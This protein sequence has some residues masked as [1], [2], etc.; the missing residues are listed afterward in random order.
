MFAII[1]TGSKQYKVI[2]GQT[3]LVELTDS[4][5]EKTVRFDRVLLT[6]SD[7]SVA[8]G[9][10]YVAGAYCE[11]EILG[12]VKGPK[13]ISFKYIRREKSATKR[14]HRQNYLKVRIKEIHEAKG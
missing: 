11:G 12:R 9:A 14:G 4:A 2:Q 10:P 3:L 5:N 8:I 13:V 7:K 6:A 1:E